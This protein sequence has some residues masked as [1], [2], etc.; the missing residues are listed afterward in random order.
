VFKQYARLPKSVYIIV[1]ATVINSMGNFIR[2][3]L[4]IF[5]T[6]RLGL[7]SSSAGTIVTISIALYVPA[8]LLGGKLVDTYGR[9]K[10]LIIFNSLSALAFIICGISFNPTVFIV[11]ILCSSFAISAAQPAASAMMADI[12]NEGNRKAAFS[13]QYLGNNLG[14]AL[15]PMIAGFLYK[16]YTSFIFFGDALTTILSLIL[17][18]K[19]VPDTM[20]KRNCDEQLNLSKK[21]QFEEGNALSALLRRPFLLILALISMLYSFV[22]CQHIFSLPIQLNGIY[23]DLGPKYFGLLMSTNALTV[24]LCSTLVTSITSKFKSIYNISLAGIFYAIGFGMI[25]FVNSISL[26]ILSTFI[27]T[28]GEILSAVNTKVFVADNTPASHR[29]RFNAIIDTISGTGFAL[30]PWIT[31]ILLNNFELKWMWALSF[32]IAG[33]GAVLMY[34]LHIF[35]SRDNLRITE[36]M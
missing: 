25:F 24:V 12:T 1:L 21:E 23:K 36:K 9:K 22:Y 14:F 16:N 27:W 13:L 15:G 7:S 6:D 4:T 35:E 19:H 29:G 2:P 3:F 31:G 17:L 10:V 5:L 28:I 8:A 26:L 34:S 20:P 11:L 18:A 30:G 32:L 33:I